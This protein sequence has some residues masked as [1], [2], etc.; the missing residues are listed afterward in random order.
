MGKFP[1]GMRIPKYY[2]DFGGDYSERDTVA[3]MKKERAEYLE[4][5]LPTEEFAEKFDE[6]L[7]VVLPGPISVKEYSVGDGRKICTAPAW[8]RYYILA[9]YLALTAFD[10]RSKAVIG[11]YSKE[12]ALAFAQA[13]SKL[14]YGSKLCLS[15]A[16]GKDAELVAYLKGL[17]AE[18]DT[19]TCVK[20]F[21]TPYCYINFDDAAGYSI[22]P[23]EANYGPYPQATLTGLFA[24]LYSFDLKAALGEKLPECIAVAMTTGTDAIGA[25][26]AFMDEKDVVLATVEETVSK[27]FHLEDSG[28]Y[29]LATRSADY[30]EPD[31]TICPQVAHWWRMAKVCR[32]GCDRIFPVNAKC[33]AELGLGT[34]AARAAALTFE[35]TG[36]S[37]ILVLE[38]SK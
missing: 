36:C 22:I 31:T 29:T 14:G 23:V 30:D 15:E 21:D 6:C 17:G 28:S 10:G 25:L 32:L 9:G 8:A 38:E 13:C 2:G 35:A 7:R 19:E 16:L 12:M 24:G 33:F 20:L 5:L 18:V 1:Q 37:E 3:P 11:T 27:E 26:A 4:K 34:R